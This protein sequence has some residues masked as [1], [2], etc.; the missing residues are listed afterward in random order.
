[1]EVIVGSLASTAGAGLSSL[2]T[3]STMATVLEGGLTAASAM[4]QFAAGGRQRALANQTAAAQVANAGA[5][6]AR[7]EQ[8]AAL[9]FFAA[10]E[11]EAEA[12]LAFRDYEF[13]ASQEYLAGKSQVISQQE[14]LAR[15]LSRNAVA[16][17]ASGVDATSG[18]AARRAEA[19]EAR[20]ASDRE[21]LESNA[22]IRQLDSLLKGMAVVRTAGSQAFQQ[23]E[24]G[25]AM[26]QDAET[27]RRQ[28]GLQANITRARGANQAMAANIKGLS[29]LG[30]FGVD[31]LRRK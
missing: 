2:A 20:A 30:Q 4:S 9:K 12:A 11:I 22:T 29:T 24:Q 31:V 6:A 17:A 10:D 13:T 27:T 15:T 18:T 16:Y 3:S 23:R 25:I 21:I 7:A 8:N 26:Q 14:D 19:A 1:M 5:M 28:A